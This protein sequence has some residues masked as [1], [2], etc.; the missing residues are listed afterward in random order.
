MYVPVHHYNYS[1]PYTY[2]CG[3]NHHNKKYEQLAI[4]SCYRIGCHIIHMMHLGKSDQQ[5]VHGIQHEFNTHKNDDS[6][7]SRQHTNNAYAEQGDCEEYIVVYRHC[8]C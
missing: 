1:Q 5:Q 7:S 2:L 6:I 8:G 4:R 3:G